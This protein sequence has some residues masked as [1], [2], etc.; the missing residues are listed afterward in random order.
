MLALYFF[1]ISWAMVDTLLVAFPEPATTSQN[2]QFYPFKTN[3][4][5][6]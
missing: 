1:L 2:D 3:P 5:P 6:S 4:V